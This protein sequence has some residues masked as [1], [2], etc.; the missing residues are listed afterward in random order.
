M[1]KQELHT[2]LKRHIT[3]EQALDNIYKFVTTVTPWTEGEERI[4]NE[5]YSIIMEARG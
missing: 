4:L 5:I 3:E 2:I 1:E